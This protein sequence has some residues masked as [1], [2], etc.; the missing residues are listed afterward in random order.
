MQAIAIKQKSQSLQ[1]PYSPSKRAASLQSPRRRADRPLK[2]TF[3]PL[4]PRPLWHF[5]SARRPSLCGCARGA[6]LRLRLRLRLRAASARRERE[7]RADASGRVPPLGDTW[8][9]REGAGA[10]RASRRRAAVRSAPTGRRPSWR[11]VPRASE[12]SRRTLKLSPIVAQLLR[13][14]WYDG[15]S[16]RRRWADHLE[17]RWSPQA[18]RIAAN[19]WECRWRHSDRPACRTE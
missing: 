6:P 13:M 10:G 17:K 15:K 7:R 14:H 1:S 8:A 2:T 9:P 16:L 5:P 19:W 18:D 11:R 3:H 12:R 4:S